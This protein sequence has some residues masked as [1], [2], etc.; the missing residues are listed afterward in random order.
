MQESFLSPGQWQMKMTINDMKIPGMPPAMA[1]R[2]KSAMGEA[3]T[4]DHCV[5]EE[6]AKKPKEDFFSGDKA[7]ACRYDSFTMGGGKMAMVM[8]CNHAT[9]K[10]VVTMDGTYGPD[11]YKMTMASVMTGKPGSPVAGM[12]FNA[13]MDAKR[14]GV[15][16]GKE[17][18]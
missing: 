12:T 10:Q 8:Q 9:G 18:K 5:T 15:C 2:M 17:S 7:A 14:T 16:T 1:G 6:E 4:F 13:T 3:R 11:S